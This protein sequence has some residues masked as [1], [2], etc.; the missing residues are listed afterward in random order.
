[1]DN[2][3]QDIVTLIPRFVLTLCEPPVRDT[4]PPEAASVQVE[5][6]ETLLPEGANDLWARAPEEAFETLLP[7]AG[8]DYHNSHPLPARSMLRRLPSLLD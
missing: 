3:D 8:H 2:L 4:L 1:M 6:T 7:A 5:V